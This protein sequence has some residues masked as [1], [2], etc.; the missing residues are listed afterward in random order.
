[1]WFHW[2]TTNLIEPLRLPRFGQH[3]SDENGLAELDL[4]FWAKN[5]W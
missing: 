5:V 3:S 2:F 4:D 1:M